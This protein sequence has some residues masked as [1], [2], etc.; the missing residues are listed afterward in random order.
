[1]Y[2]ENRAV[3]SFNWC[4]R[5]GHWNGCYPEPPTHLCPP[6]RPANSCVFLSTNYNWMPSS[7]R[8]S[9]TPRPLPFI[10]KS[11]RSTRSWQTYHLVNFFPPFLQSTR[12]NR[13]DPIQSKLVHRPPAGLISVEPVIQARHNRLNSFHLSVRE[14]NDFF[15]LSSKRNFPSFSPPLPTVRNK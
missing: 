4:C 6:F 3:S 12:V 10:I 2:L 15:F 1:M 11:D 13:I 14:S 7:F 8:G 9:T 5:I